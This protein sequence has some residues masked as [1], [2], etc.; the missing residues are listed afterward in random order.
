L[1]I[2]RQK[3]AF[4]TQLK[5]LSSLYERGSSRP[6]LEKVATLKGT[7]GVNYAKRKLLF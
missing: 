2:S 5:D 7:E 4:T 3:Y 6:S 1:V